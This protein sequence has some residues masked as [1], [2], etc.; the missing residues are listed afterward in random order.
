MRLGGVAHVVGHARDPVRACLL[1]Q[2]VP[3]EPD[4]GSRRLVSRER[5]VLHLMQAVGADGA[6]GPPRLRLATTPAEEERLDAV[7]RP[8]GTGIDVLRREPPIV[9]AP[10]AGF[11]EAK[12]WP[13]ESFAALADRLAREDAPVFVVGAPGEEA[14]VASVA[15]A[16]RTS[17]VVL[18]GVLDLGAFKVLLRHARLLVANDA[19]ARHIAAA[20]AVPSVVFFGPTSVAKTPDNLE[21]VEVL[22]TDH[23]CRPCYLRRCPIDHRCLRSLSVDRAEQAARRAMARSNAQTGWRTIASDEQGA[24]LVR[25][26]SRLIDLSVLIASYEN[27]ELLGAC[28]DALR[29]ARDAHPEIELEVIVVDNGSRDASVARARASGLPVRVVALV[30][31]RGF[32]AA[33]NLGLR[34]RRGRHVLLLNSD[35]LVEPDV[36]ARAV[37]LLDRDDEIG[38]LGVALLHPGGRAQRSVHAFPSLSTELLPDAWVRAWRRAR[39]PGRGR[40]PQSTSDRLAS[41]RSGIRDVEAVRGAVFFVRGSL[42]EALGELDE[43]YFFFLEETD[44][45][46]RVRASGHRVVYDPAL[47]ATHQLGASSKARAPLATRI[48]YER[49]LDRFLRDPARPPSRLAGSG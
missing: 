31:N 28:L 24:R 7:L 48:E 13:A 42:L 8:L 9:L 34:I 2:R 1:H 32:A 17:P 22:E 49:S 33:V 27:A 11:G 47:R 20:F 10:G 36:L 45:C 38:V 6:E 14:L 44:F 40:R 37:A 39:D 46:W 5:F 19:G 23:A 30:R 25:G 16:M 3:D 12:C 15:R 26:R 18:A 21:R 35:A 43:G 41:I 4:W 29:R